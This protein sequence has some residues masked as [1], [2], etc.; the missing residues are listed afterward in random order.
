MLGN[1]RDQ[2]NFQKSIGVLLS[3]NINIM[4]NNDFKAKDLANESHSFRIEVADG[5]V[6]KYFYV[7]PLGQGR[8]EIL[9]EEGTIGTLQLDERDHAHCES[10]GC[11]LDLPLLHAIRDQIQFHQN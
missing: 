1:L 5:D 6:G 9:D 10:Q 7:K 8:Y 3:I 4:E 2:H 11:E